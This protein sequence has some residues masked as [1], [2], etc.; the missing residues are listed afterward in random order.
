MK[1]CKTNYFVPTTY[2]EAITCKEAAKWKH[3]M[4]T[5]YS[6][7]LLNKTWE[8]DPVDLPSD[9]SAVG[10]KWVY[11]IKINVN[12]LSQNLFINV[13]EIEPNFQGD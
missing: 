2:Q 9:R 5:E 13:G 11:T 6:S 8:T 12:L 10:T 7:L 1:K 3:A 4:D